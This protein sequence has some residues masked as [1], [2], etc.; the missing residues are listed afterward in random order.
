[1]TRLRQ[2]SPSIVRVLNI[3]LVLLLYRL[4]KGSKRKR[5][6]TEHLYT[7]LR[8][9]HPFRY[10]MQT[11]L[12]RLIAYRLCLYVA[13]FEALHC[14]LVPTDKYTQP[15]YHIRGTHDSNT[16]SFKGTGNCCGRLSR[17]RYISNFISPVTYSTCFV[18]LTQTQICLLLQS[19]RSTSAVNIKRLLSATSPRRAK[20]DQ[21]LKCVPVN[22][23]W[24]GSEVSTRL[25]NTDLDPLQTK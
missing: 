6:E 17:E 21:I 20:L 13:H 14:I 16:H 25:P 22:V 7:N 5:N 9:L 2:S 19:R 3:D 10:L 11:V 18:G 24:R 8:C 4:Q 15:K 23:I 1:M 12:Q